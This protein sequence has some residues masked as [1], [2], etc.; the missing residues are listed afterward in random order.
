MASPGW[1][2]GGLL[3]SLSSSHSS[4]SGRAMSLLPAQMQM[5]VHPGSSRPHWASSRDRRCLPRSLVLRVPPPSQPC[6][7]GS[8][9]LRLKQVL[10][11]LEDSGESWAAHEAT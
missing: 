5:Q 3:L 9:R 10:W 8:C 2:G 4:S 6:P 11:L 7:V 1:G